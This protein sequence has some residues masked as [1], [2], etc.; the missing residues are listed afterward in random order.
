METLRADQRRLIT[1]LQGAL[2]EVDSANERRE[3][4]G[5]TEA[6]RRIG[7]IEDLV[8]QMI[9][10]MSDFAQRLDDIYQVVT[11]L[12]EASPPMDGGSVG[13]ESGSGE[14]EYAEEG[15]GLYTLA[16]NMYNV[17][18]YETARDAFRSFLAENGEHELAPD[19]QFYIGRSFEDEG[20][21]G[22]ALTEYRRVSELFPDSNR[23]PA[24]LY[25][26]G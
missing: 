22:S 8:E 19:A 23:A 4:T 25:R 3:A 14:S 10:V 18:N 16:L 13:F 20:D 1:Q 15:L 11:D 24:A 5:R 21:P 12:A 26:R 17:G 9:G 6:D 7:R 2:V